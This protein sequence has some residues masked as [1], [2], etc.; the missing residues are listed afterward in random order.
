MAKAVIMP[1]FSMT[2]EEAVIIQWLVLDG[3]SVA[4]GDPLLEV[5]TDKVIM[6]VEAP[7]DGI[8]AGIRYREGDTVPVTEIIAYILADGETLPEA[9]QPTPSTGISQSA[10]SDISA[11]APA[12]EPAALRQPAP[13][14]PIARRLAASEGIDLTDIGGSG[15]GGKI[16]RKD[17]ELHRAKAPEASSPRPG[18]GKTRATPAA[19][20]SARAHQV[21]LAAIAG[22]GPRGRIQAADVEAALSHSRQVPADRDTTAAV[23]MVTT[24]PLEGRRR[25]IAQRAQTSY[26]EAPHIMLTLDVDMTEALLLRQYANAHLDEERPEISMTAIIIQACAWTLRQ[27]PII[28][29]H[30]RDDHIAVMQDVNVGMAVAL[31]EGLVVP[32]IRHTDRKGLRQI[33][34]EIVDLI[35]RARAGRLRPDDVTGGT[36]TVSN[37]GM[38]GIDHFTAIIYPPQVGILAIGRIA[39]RFVP[40]ADDNPVARP[41]MTVTLA[42]DHRAIDGAIAAQFL[43]TLREALE[44]PVSELL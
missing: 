16:M 22:S 12:R 1:K 19:R 10:A 23:E 27:R 8:I 2:Q 43:T 3:D 9:P 4:K 5:E 29:S 21:E 40:D 28:N 33:G 18:N 36:F 26:Q 35:E 11:P 34:V 20:R 17:V 7:T 39:K 15:P 38:F 37:L 44:H 13:A 24:I 6:E 42:V 41:M 25:T 31:D 14:S 32:V 30:F